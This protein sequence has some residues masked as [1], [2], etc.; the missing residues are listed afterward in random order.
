M[1]LVKNHLSALTSRRNFFTGKSSLAEMTNLT[2]LHV[3]S[4]AELS[5][6]ET[7]IQL[8]PQLEAFHVGYVV[9]RVSYYSR[10]N[11]LTSCFLP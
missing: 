11:D 7:L 2:E 1:Q 6:L 5:Q 8:T 4:L 3:K 10:T 9:V